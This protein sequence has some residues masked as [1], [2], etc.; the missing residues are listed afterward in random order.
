MQRKFDRAIV[1]EAHTRAVLVGW[2]YQQ[3][4]RL[5]TLAS[6]TAFQTTTSTPHQTPLQALTLVQLRMYLSRFLLLR[7]IMPSRCAIISSGRTVVFSEI[8]TMSMAGRGDAKES[9]HSKQERSM[10][11]F[12]FKKSTTCYWRKTAT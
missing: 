2:E 6:V 12:T 3:G 10:Y 4:Q 7:G 1:A 11:V 8:S 5:G 9:K